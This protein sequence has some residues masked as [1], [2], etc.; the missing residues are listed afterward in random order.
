M[1]GSPTDFAKG[2]IT[3]PKGGIS[4]LLIAKKYERW[5]KA[6]ARILLLEGVVSR[7]EIEVGA[8]KKLIPPFAFARA[9]AETVPE[10]VEG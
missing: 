2:K 4:F 6:S 7:S 5:R 8:N 3:S 10:L 1:C 9:C